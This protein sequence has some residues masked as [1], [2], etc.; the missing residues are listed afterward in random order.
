M[1]T[2]R[3]VD[4]MSTVP[5]DMLAHVQAQAGVMSAML[6]EI[7]CW[8]TYHEAGLTQPPG[9]EPAKK[10]KTAQ[11]TPEEKLA[12]QEK[13]NE[14]LKATLKEVRDA[15]KEIQRELDAKKREVKKLEK[16][17]A[18]LEEGEQAD[19]ASDDKKDAGLAEREGQLA[20]QEERLRLAEAE[21]KKR[22]SD[23]AAKEA[24]V[25]TRESAARDCE[26]EALRAAEKY[27]AKR[28]GLQQAQELQREIQHICKQNPQI[29]QQLSETLVRWTSERR[30]VSPDTALR[31]C[32]SRS[33]SRAKSQVPREG[34]MMPPS[35]CRNFTCHPLS[36]RSENRAPSTRRLASELPPPPAVPRRLVYDEDKA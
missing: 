30:N 5:N 24:D 36:L 17:V 14:K 29:R 12:K 18:S 15:K 19:R 31:T 2:K 3:G 23:V 34:S 9:R 32:I 16:R 35:S 25:Q 20:A 4:L 21:V 27:K 33:E 22:A 7:E 1:A 26:Q 13:E 10:R 6:S 8:R 28:R 11:L